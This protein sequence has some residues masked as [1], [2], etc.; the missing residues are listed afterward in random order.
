MLLA[1]SRRDLNLQLREKPTTIRGADSE[2][3][4]MSLRRKILDVLNGPAV[5][6]IRFRFPIHGS[7]VTVAPQT[8]QHVARAI[9][10]AQVRVRAPTDLAAGGAVCCANPCGRYSGGGEHAGSR[11]CGGADGPG[12]Y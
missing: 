1:A 10:L 3:N 11:V 6:R 9:R 4:P 5:A 2:D 7:H 8:F 12:L